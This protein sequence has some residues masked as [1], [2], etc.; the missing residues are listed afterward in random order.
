[1]STEEKEIITYIADFKEMPLSS[2]TKETPIK[3]N[4]LLFERFVAGLEKRVGINLTTSEL[5]S[6]ETVEDLFK[7]LP[8]ASSSSL[9][10]EKALP[11]KQPSEGSNRIYSGI[12]IE[13]VDSFRGKVDVQAD[14][15]FKRLF[16]P[17][18]MAYCMIQEDPP[19]HFAARFCAKEAIRKCGEFFINIPYQ[20]I[21]ICNKENGEPYTK[22]QGEKWKNIS[23]SL[24]HTR[25]FA[26]ANAVFSQELQTEQFKISLEPHVTK[27]HN[28][29]SSIK[30]TAANKRYSKRSL[31]FSTLAVL[32]IIESTAIGLLWF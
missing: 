16:T 13:M 1:M 28:E 7:L 19:Q 21:E 14:D 6:A 12:D 22:I 15:T 30:E 2:V 25:D 24:S 27:Q 11:N 10:N 3:L 9:A 29:D 4:S 20:E 26:V 5:K 18:E 8:K 23:I 32:V 31:L 17:V